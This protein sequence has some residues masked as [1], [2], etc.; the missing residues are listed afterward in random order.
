MIGHRLMGMAL[1][2]TGDISKGRAHYDQALALYDPAEHRPLALRFGQDVAV[3]T[4]S[5]RAMASWTLG[6][7]QAALADVENALKY[8]REISQAATLEIRL[9]LRMFGSPPSTF[10]CKRKCWPV[11]TLA[12][13]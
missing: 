13:K 8:A 1:L 9:Q 2:H 7:P 10:R 5:F 11:A 4:L 6:Y 3:A 12:S